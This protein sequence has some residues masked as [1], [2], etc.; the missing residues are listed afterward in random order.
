[1]NGRKIPVYGNGSNV[2]DWLHVDDHCRGIHAVLMRGRSGEIYNIGGGVELTNLELTRKILYLLGK[3]ES[4]VEFVADRPGHDMRYSVNIRK[5]SDELGYKPTVDLNE[6]LADTVDW[7]QRN[8]EWW[9]PL[10]TRNG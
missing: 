9:H 7:Y 10:K 3:N 1:M 6:G 5:I 4:N 8:E 2:R